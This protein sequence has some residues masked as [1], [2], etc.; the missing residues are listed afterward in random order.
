MGLIT[1]MTTVMMMAPK[2]ISPDLFMSLDMDMLKL[3]MLAKL[4]EKL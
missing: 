2:V 3:V 1:A 4:L